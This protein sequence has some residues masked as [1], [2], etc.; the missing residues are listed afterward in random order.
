MAVDWS[1]AL[2]GAFAAGF[3]VAAV[4]FLRM[5]RG[6]RQPLLIFFAAAFALLAV[7]YGVL[8]VLHLDERDQSQIYLIRFAAFILIIAGI[9]V[10][11]LRWGDDP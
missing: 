5:W 3:L 6:E 10:T 9:I 8:G 2:H 4:L 11:N 7:N 1:S